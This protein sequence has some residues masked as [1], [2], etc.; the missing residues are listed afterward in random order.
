MQAN[1][2]I[3]DFLVAV[4]TRTLVVDPRFA[5]SVSTPVT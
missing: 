4:Y 3:V 1:V 5:K 2:G